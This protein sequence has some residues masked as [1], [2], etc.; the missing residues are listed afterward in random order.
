MASNTT[1]SQLLQ[2]ATIVVQDKTNIHWTQEELISWLNEAYQQIV[3]LRPD[4]NSDTI[5]VSLDAGT[6]Q[7]I[8][9]GGV[10]LIT[11]TR[12]TNG[13]AIR[14]IER[15]VLDDQIPDWHTKAG[16][17]SIQHFV[18]DLNNPKTFYVYPPANVGTQ[19]E[20]VYAS[21]PT[22]HA[23]NTGAILLDDRY[24]PALLDYILYRAYQKDAD[25]AAN[26]QR[27]VSAYQ[28]FIN[29]LGAGQTVAKG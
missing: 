9:D 29:S 25:Y 12:N 16:V 28:T 18:Y 23:D 20:V 11:V 7:S 19:V 3:L 14:Y 4:A 21:V 2:N 24:A 5:D 27:S 13:N 1:V 6:K 22:P 10:S 8:P 17:N 15:A 26:D